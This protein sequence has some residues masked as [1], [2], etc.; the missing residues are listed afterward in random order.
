MC[1][2]SR[3]AKKRGLRLNSTASRRPL[4][5]SYR[6]RACVKNAIL[7]IILFGED[8]TCVL[9]GTIARRQQRAARSRVQVLAVGELK[10][11]SKQWTPRLREKKG[12]KR[13][14]ERAGGGEEGASAAA[15]MG[16][17]KDARCKHH[18]LL[19][20]LR[21]VGAAARDPQDDV[22]D[23]GEDEA[24]GDDP[25]ATQTDGRRGMNK[26]VPRRTCTETHGRGVHV[27]ARLL[28]LAVCMPSRIIRLSGVHV[29]RVKWMPSSWELTT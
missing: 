10:H 19:V 21:Q 14:T 8:G 1:Q 3:K 27:A 9:R 23:D 7:F 18:R 20:A 5:G 13:S 16:E 17:G 15:A 28:A 22:D 25:G 6:G 11:I 26:S 24:D 4:G 29:S 12:A 2:V